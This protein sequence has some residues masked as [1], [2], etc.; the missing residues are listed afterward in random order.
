MGHKFEHQALFLSASFLPFSLSQTNPKANQRMG[1]SQRQPTTTPVVLNV[2]DLHPS[3]NSFYSY[4]IGAFH[5]GL[6]VDGREYC[7]GG[8]PPDVAGEMTGVHHITPRS[9]P[10]GPYRTS[11][12]ME[13]RLT[14]NE[15]QSIIAELSNDFKARDYNVI[16]KN[17]N[18]FTD[19]LSRRLCGRGIPSWVNRLATLGSWFSCFLPRGFGQPQPQNATQNP[20]NTS[21]DDASSTSQQQGTSNSF[22]AFSGEGRSLSTPHAAPSRSA[23]SSA[24]HENTTSDDAAKRRE[25]LLQAS[26]SRLNKGNSPS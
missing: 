26:L 19:A 23:S 10:E 16:S 6:D 1:K 13:T 20:T 17:C 25:L 14:R 7:Y 15:I 11:I 2:Y 12:Q 5:S 24:S 21:S 18:H 3:N 9:A 4:G 22:I 8:A